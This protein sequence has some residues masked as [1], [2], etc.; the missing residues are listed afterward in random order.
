MYV[1]D[2][3]FIDFDDEYLKLLK[4]R[5]FKRFKIIDLKSISYYLRMSITRLNDRIILN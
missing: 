1:K 2:I 4:K 5:L 3:L